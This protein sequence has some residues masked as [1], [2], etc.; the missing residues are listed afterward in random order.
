MLRK[1]SAILFPPMSGD[2]KARVRRS[3]CLM[4]PVGAVVSLF[5]GIV[6]KLQNPEDFR[7]WLIFAVTAASVGCW[8]LVQKNYL[9]LSALVY[10]VSLWAIV[11]S[12]IYYSGGIQTFGQSG[13]ILII[14]MT[15]LL[16]GGRYALILVVLSIFSMTWILHQEINGLLVPYILHIDPVNSLILFLI[17]I[18][19]GWLL[20][21]LTMK[22]LRLALDD[23]SQELAERRRAEKAL[24]AQA[25]YL[26]ALHETT[27][28]IINRLDLAS[29]LESILGRAEALVNTNHGCIDLV[30]PDGT[31]SQEYI[32]H[33]VF[34]PF[35]GVVVP[36]GQG[37][38]GLALQKKETVVID[39]YSQWDARLTNY[40]E[41]GLHALLAIPLQVEGRVIGIIK[42]SYDDPGRKFT[43]QQIQQL[44]QFAELAA[45]A[46]DNASLYHAVQ[47]ELAERTR[48]ESALRE[49]QARLDLALSSAN[50]GIWDWEIKTDQIIWSE[51][52]YEVLGVHKEN[53]A[54][55]L[56]NYLISIHPRDRGSVKQHID[57]CLA[58]IEPDYHVEYRILSDL[59]KSFWLEAQGRV[60]RDENGN[61]TR[62]TGTI[63]NI[64]ERK[65]DEQVIKNANVN[66]KNYAE[67]LERRS[68]LLQLG[69]EVAR[70]ATAILN[71]H[72]LSQQVVEMVQKQFN[73]Y[74][75]G[76]FVVEDDPNWA[77]LRAG[78]GSAGI[79]M[80][81]N[82]HRLEVGDTSMIGWCIAH[83][84]ARIALDVGEEAVR[85]NNPLLPN[86]R[87]ELALPLISRGEV[88]GALT[89]QS[90]KQA[91]FS[92]EDIATFETMADLLAN[93]ILNA[94]LYD[95]VQRELEERKRAE[96]K[97]RQL[98]VELEARV[99]RRTAALKAS[100]E[101][102]RALA[103]NNP[104]QIARYDRDG[105]YLY[106]NHLGESEKLR[107]ENVIGKTL[108]EVFG[109]HPRID[110]AEEKIRRVF[111]SGESLKTEYK[112][113]DFVGHWSLSPEFDPQGN[114]ISVISTTLDISERKR[115]EDELQ[116]TNR[117]LEA[118]S[119]SV[120][121][122]LRAPLRA[123]DGFTRILMDD[124][125]SQIPEDGLIFLQRTRQAAQQMGQ[126][127]DDLLR[128][129]RI[130][131]AE[132][133][134]QSVDIDA[135][136]YEIFEQLTLQ[137]PERAVKFHV[138]KN[139]KATG[140]ER[141]LRVA[142][143]NLLNNAWK[144]TANIPNPVIKVGKTKLNGKQTFYI[145]DNGV[146][147]NMDY[148]DKLFGAFQRLHTADEFPG[149]G[150]GLAIVQRIIHKHGGQVW[151]ESQPGKGTTFYF[152]V[153]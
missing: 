97:V 33:G 83:N 141:L 32:G 38:T 79:I 123:I 148:V 150:I 37:I 48:A 53:F 30:L 28:A 118:F 16:L 152:T 49:S 77:V 27:L 56:E 127:I 58:G 39:N 18:I 95:Q 47:D 10:A 82:G 20:L 99:K 132:L 54:N 41:L 46:L 52:V 26:A 25:E 8:F 93:A 74:Y 64:T 86:T 23:A 153:D 2:E 71:S 31:S 29:L 35:L 109:N 121:H 61:P 42:L 137:E 7:H 4:L 68:G 133:H 117:E 112:L 135:L 114:V 125:T 136:A 36:I 3:L 6:Y 126:L 12:V 87:S 91:A 131:R 144:F 50:M 96:D 129:S 130:T 63:T 122:D 90:N 113:M 85:F 104:L 81:E 105:R 98:N 107:P 21:S 57:N 40:A 139:L 45:L 15:G 19:A 92:Q 76:L 149:T 84:Q 110:F 78:T 115:I 138:A 142:L 34:E 116:A 111:E 124:F 55:N 51:S 101:K 14:F 73:L 5:Y 69:A 143:E 145:H 103:E 60:Y 100:E 134:S 13:L 89:I 119:Y 9:R 72:A 59:D 146:G 120:S 17:Y 1:I 147:F 94:R 106:V 62:M 43:Q 151:A 44:E 75:V 140:D 65:R 102:F 80:L 66:L 22:N 11:S 108:R 67:V 128:L 88:L 24:S 70:A